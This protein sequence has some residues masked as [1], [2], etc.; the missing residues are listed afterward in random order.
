V[1]EFILLGSKIT[2]DGDF[3]HEIKRH[4]FLGRKVITNLD[5]ILKS[6]DII[7]WQR[8]NSLWLLSW[9]LILCIPMDCIMPSFPVH[10]QIP[11]LIQTLVHWVDDAIQPPCPLLSPAPAAFNLSQNQDFFQMTQFFTPGGQHI[12]VSPL[13]LI[14]PMNIQDWL[15]LLSVQGTL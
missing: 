15:D 13:A 4:L 10:H 11:E 6:R 3:S 14:L 8:F 9:C 7:F 1:R 12:G 2:V 5:S